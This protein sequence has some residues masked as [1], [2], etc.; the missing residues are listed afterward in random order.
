MTWA[1]IRPAPLA[2]AALPARSRITAI[3]GADPAVLRVVANGESPLR[4]I[5][6]P[7][8]LVSAGGALLGMPVDR[9]Q[10][11]VDVDEHRDRGGVG[12]QLVRALPIRVAGRARR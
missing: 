5:C 4:R 11:R 9:A 10:Q 12:E 7:P 6:L 2:E 8:I 3:T 1:T